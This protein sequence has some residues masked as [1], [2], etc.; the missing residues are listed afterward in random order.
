MVTPVRS[1]GQAPIAQSAERLH[2]KEKVNG[3][4]PFGGSQSEQAKRPVRDHSEPGVRVSCGPFATNARQSSTFVDTVAGAGAL[5]DTRLPH[6]VKRVS[7]VIVLPSKPEVSKT[8]VAAYELLTL[9]TR[10]APLRVRR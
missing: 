1:A 6:E 7:M 10:P 5:M 2:G 4:I 8:P 3:S 9:V